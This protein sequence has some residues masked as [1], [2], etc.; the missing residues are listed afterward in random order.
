MGPRLTPFETLVPAPGSAVT[1]L[2]VAV[3]AHLTV[4]VATS[5]GSIAVYPTGAT[6]PSKTLSDPAILST[7]EIAVD[8]A[9]N[10]FLNYVVPVANNSNGY[11]LGAVPAVTSIRETFFHRLNIDSAPNS[12]QPL[13]LVLAAA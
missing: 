4:Y 11:A 9:G 7:Y 12:P 3:D 6:T 1:F 2:S 10:I 8:G 5:I 13:G